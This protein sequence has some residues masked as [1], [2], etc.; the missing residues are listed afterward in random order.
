MS[1]VD[2]DIV[3]FV[4]NAHLS[5][6]GA[7]VINAFW[8]Q[9]SELTGDLSTPEDFR[10]VCQDVFLTITDVFRNVQSIHLLYDNLVM[11]NMTNGIDFGVYAPTVLVTGNVNIESD[12]GQ[13]AL[14]FKLQR[15]N[16]LTRNGSK[17]VGGIAASLITDTDGSDLVGTANILAIQE[18]LAAP[19]DIAGIISGS[20]VLTPMIVRRTATGVAPTVFQPVFGAIFRGV[21]SQT[22]RK[23]L[24]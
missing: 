22:T 18:M 5:V 11:D 2:G 23:R 19:I 24:L 3:R 16:R 17:R 9:V 7:P 15:T 14:S 4:L 6:T 10:L 12:P 21:G 13:T 8:F 20:C 1:L